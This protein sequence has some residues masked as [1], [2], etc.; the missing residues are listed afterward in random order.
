MLIITLSKIRPRG[1]ILSRCLNS[2]IPN[3]PVECVHKN[4]N[5]TTPS[6][7]VQVDSKLVAHLERLS[8]VDFSN[9]EG[10]RRL[11]EAIRFAQ[12]LKDVDT[13][14]IEPMISVLEDE[15]LRL[16]PDI[17]QQDNSKAD[18]LANA[19]VVEEDFFVAP[20]GNIPL[21]VG[22]NKYSNVK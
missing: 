4:R 13:T 22:E 7:V 1:P 8:L 19:K 16:R 5:N 3:K 6:P 11:E 18:I 21:E 9:E 20:P 2:H 17:E 14:G 10:V 15:T 12:P